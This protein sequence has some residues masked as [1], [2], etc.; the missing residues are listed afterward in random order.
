MSCDFL[1]PFLQATVKEPW[2]SPSPSSVIDSPQPY[3]NPS[4][5][6]LSARYTCRVTCWYYLSCKETEP[7]LFSTVWSIKLQSYGWFPA[8]EVLQLGI[9]HTLSITQHYV[10]C[11]FSSDA[12]LSLFSTGFFEFVALP[13]FKAWSKLFGSPFS[14]LLV[15]NIL[16]NKAYWDGQMPRNHSSDS[17]ED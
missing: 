4:Q 16:N 9:R 11:V 6:R 5:V 14:I 2:I 15:K 7:T 10:F 1:S 17:E 13:L 12:F 3:Q 8:C